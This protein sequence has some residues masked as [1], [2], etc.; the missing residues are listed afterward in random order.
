[1]SLVIAIAWCS[2][3]VFLSTED[4]FLRLQIKAGQ[5]VFDMARALFE[6][7]FI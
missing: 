6:S 3:V 2:Q 4:V 7:R 5:S 1:M